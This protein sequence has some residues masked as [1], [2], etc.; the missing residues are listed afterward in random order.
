MKKIKKFFLIFLPITLIIP[1]F[2][3][4]CMG[5]RTPLTAQEEKEEGMEL[6]TVKKGDIYQTVDITGFVDA[7][8]ENTYV[9]RVSGEIISA[10]QK[11]DFFNKGDVLIEVDSSDAVNNIEDIEKNLEIAKNSLAQSKINYQDALDKNHIAI[12]LADIDKEK[13]ALSSES[14][15]LSFKEASK[16]AD[17]SSE[18]AQLAVE[19]SQTAFNTSQISK[20]QAEQNLEYAQNALEDAK[21]DSSTSDQEIMQ[22]EDNV[23]TAEK[24]LTKAEL[25]LQSSELS[26]Q[27]AENSL[28]ESIIQSESQEESAEISYKQALKNQ[29]S[30]YWS[31]LENMQSAEKQMQ[32][33]KLNMKKAE[34]DLEMAELELEL[35]N[36]ELE[37]YNVTAPYDGIVTSTDCKTSQYSSNGSI[38]I[39]R[40]DFLFNATVDETLIPNIL[41]GDKAIIDLDAYPD[42]EFEGEV[43]RIIPVFT[44]E[45]G[46]ISYEVLIRA[47]V[48]ENINLL[49]GLSANIS[50]VADKAEGVLYVPIQSVY[51]EN[52]KSYVD[53]L[54]A[55]RRDDIQEEPVKKVEVSIGIN[56]YYNIEITSGLKE[57]DKVIT[58]RIE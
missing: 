33:A 24:N 35:A 13:A 14:A 49:Y 37:N 17:K 32:I 11:G 46:I 19:T 51:K 54:A 5:I 47:D 52:G 44:D 29:S 31:T 22:L 58:S 9:L 15:L 20:Q 6:F 39:I 18:S 45:D 40:D 48:P 55:V 7:E 23:K 12:Q 30:T 8:Q 43:E 16:L 57:G 1:L 41:E 27:Q 38:S 25:S 36:D 26:L 50:I 53:I 10:L 4:S 28:S 21:A 56:D 34:I 2:I 3:S 42:T